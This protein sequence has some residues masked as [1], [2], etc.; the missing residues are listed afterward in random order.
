MIKRTVSLILTGRA[1]GYRFPV[2]AQDSG[3][4]RDVGESVAK[5]KKGAVSSDSDWRKFL[6]S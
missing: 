2:G 3:P 5:P 1:C 6:Q 4:K